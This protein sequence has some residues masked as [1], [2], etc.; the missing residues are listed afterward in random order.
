[1]DDQVMGIAKQGVGRVEDAVGG[2]TGDVQT[3]AKGKLDQASGAAQQAYGQLKDGVRDAFEN[4]LEAARA[5]IHD[6][7]DDLED[8]V[9][10]KPLPA[11]AIAGAIGLVLGLLLRGRGTT[12]YLHD[13]H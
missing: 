2:L 10:A 1:M 8:R 6:R 5:R 3:Q 7:L 9:I 13:P 11:L 12:I 4:T